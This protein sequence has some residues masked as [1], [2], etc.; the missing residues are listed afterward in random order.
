MAFG[1]LKKKGPDSGA[2]P[3]P[4]SPADYEGRRRAAEGLHAQGLV[5]Q[6]VEVL[7]GLAAD[8]AGAG[9]FP[10]AVA[11]RHQIEEWRPGTAGRSPAEDGRKMADLRAAS[12]IFRAP[13]APA[14]ASQSMTALRASPLLASLSAEEIG[15]LIESTGLVKFSRGDVALQEGTAGDDLFVVTRGAFGVET[16]GADGRSVRVGT[17]HVGDFFGEVAVLTGRPRTATVRAEADAEC[18]RL[19][20][21]NFATLEARHPRLRPLLADEMATRAQNAAEAVLE[22]LRRRREES[23]S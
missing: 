9:N 19:T 14:P 13:G 1:F 5:A 23:P 8:L 3:P 16:A 18:L 4:G 17:L 21:R 20:A 15:G 7:D 12:G 2:M 22:D 11:V 6:A 10:L